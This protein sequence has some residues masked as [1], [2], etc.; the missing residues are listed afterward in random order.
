MRVQDQASAVEIA[1]L[2]IALAAGGAYFVLVDGR[3][4]GAVRQYRERAGCHLLCHRPFFPAGRADLF[5]ALW[6]A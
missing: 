4:A 2:G 1:G 3:A 6:P 5:S